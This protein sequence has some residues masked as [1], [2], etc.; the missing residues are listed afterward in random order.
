[1]WGYKIN[2]YMTQLPELGC[3]TAFLEISSATNEVAM[4]NNGM[5]KIFDTILKIDTP[6]PADANSNA[7]FRKYAK[8][9]QEKKV[10]DAFMQ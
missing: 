4:L 9:E 5:L 6:I 7:P 1:M 3:L 10:A 8:G 2:I